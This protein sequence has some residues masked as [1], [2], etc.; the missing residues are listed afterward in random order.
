MSVRISTSLGDIDIQLYTDRC[1]LTTKNFLKLC[2]I[3][4]FNGCLFH[5]IQKGFTAHTGD[6]TGNGSDSIYKFLNSDQ[7]CFLGD[8]TQHSETGSVAMA[9]AAENLNASYFYFT[10]RDDLDYLIGKN[11]VFGEIVEGL[12]TLTRI[13]EGYLDEKGKAYE[14]IRIKHTY[15]LDDPFDDPA[16][17]SR[18][19]LNMSLEGKPLAEVVYTYLY[20]FFFLVF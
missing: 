2:K 14:N 19:I 3:K 18:L 9:S 15:I 5:N 10:L 1:P 6:P 17:L 12:E 16:E 13:N 8:E 20:L 11:T 4:Y 7:D